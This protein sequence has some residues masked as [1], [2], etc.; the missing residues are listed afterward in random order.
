MINDFFD[1]VFVISIDKEELAIAD[2]LL[3]DQGIEYEALEGIVDSNGI[4][5]LVLSMRKLFQHCLDKGYENVLVLE[6]DAE[7]LVPNVNNF[8]AETLPQLPKDYHCFYL[9][10]NLLTAPKRISQNILRVDSAYSSHAIG[11]SRKGIELIM[12]YLMRD[13]IVPYDIILMKEIQPQGLCYATIPMLCTQRVRFSRIEN[14]VTDWKS[15]MTM[16]FNMHTKNLQRMDA[17]AYCIGSHKING[18]EITVDPLKHE[19]QHP[20]LIGKICDCKKFIYGEGMCGCAIKEW[21][22]SWKENTNA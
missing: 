19:I 8:T 18:H 16:T 15:L 20:E 6:D 12:P 13:E 4:K 11:Y 3:K 22:V 1:K 21:R 2:C 7:W 10:L 5:G 9:G 14:K 17:I